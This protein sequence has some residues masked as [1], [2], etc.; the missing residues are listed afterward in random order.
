M[1]ENI[2]ILREGMK[3]G[4]KNPTSARK[5][6]VRHSNSAARSNRGDKYKGGK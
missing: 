5:L 4:N 2:C 3:A 1:Q 6:K